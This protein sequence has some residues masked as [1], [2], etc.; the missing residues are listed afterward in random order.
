MSDATVAGLFLSAVPVAFSG[1][2]TV[3][4]DTRKQHR[5]PRLPY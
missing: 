2:F 3:L 1:A 5:G 4:L